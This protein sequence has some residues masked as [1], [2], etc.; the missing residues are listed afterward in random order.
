VDGISDGAVR[1]RPIVYAPL[2]SNLAVSRNYRRRGIAESMVKAAENY[3]RNT[4]PDEYNQS[5]YLYVERRNTRAIQLYQKLGYR[6]M[7]QDGN[8]QTLLPM[9]NGNLQS[10]PTVLVCMKKNLQSSS[11]NPF[12]RLF[13]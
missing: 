2:M 8:A 9:E 12:A 4:W 10:V 13:G 6:R 11:N 5:L 3:I 1:G 7:W